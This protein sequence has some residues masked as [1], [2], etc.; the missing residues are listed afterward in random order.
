MTV[1]GCSGSKGGSGAADPA[2]LGLKGEIPKMGA[3]VGKSPE[4]ALM[5]MKNP[6]DKANYLRNLDKDADFDPKKHTEM[7][8]KYS[9]DPDADIAQA[10]KDL[11]DKAK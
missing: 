6:A 2:A 10:A 9:K 8:E 7:L 5:Q 3:S 11:L 1:V 4:L